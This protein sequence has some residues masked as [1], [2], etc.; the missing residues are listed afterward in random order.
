MKTVQIIIFLV[1][2]S[3]MTT[4]KTTYV[5]P[6]PVIEGFVPERAAIGMQVTIRGYGFGTS[7]VVNIGGIDTKINS[8]VTNTDLKDEIHI[9]VPVGAISGKIKVTRGNLVGLS[10]RNLI[11]L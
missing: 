7:P 5:D 6:G 11:I 3:V 8:I 1:C 4:C 9:D 10:Q 2:I